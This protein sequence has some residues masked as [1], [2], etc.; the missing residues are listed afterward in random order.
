M[1]S[2]KD[3]SRQTPSS[4]GAPALPPP[5]DVRVGGDGAPAAPAAIPRALAVALKDEP[6]RGQTRVTAKGQGRVAEQILAVAL[7]H[8]VKVR[9]DAD[10][11]QVL[12]AIEIDSPI[13]L[14]AL[15]AVAEILRYVYLAN[16]GTPPMESTHDRV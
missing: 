3:S 6:A 9:E 16:A 7:A 10:L 4:R 14:E 15:A 1:A 2:P 8:G 13:P 12:A 5:L 11:A